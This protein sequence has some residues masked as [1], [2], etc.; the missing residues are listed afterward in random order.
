MSGAQHTPGPRLLRVSSQSPLILKE[1]SGC[2]DVVGESMTVLGSMHTPE[3]AAEAVRRWNAHDELVEALEA[4]NRHN[5]FAANKLPLGLME[6][7][8]AAIAKATGSAA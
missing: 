3:L 1:D 5:A 2:D 6:Q 4:V 7:V 8:R